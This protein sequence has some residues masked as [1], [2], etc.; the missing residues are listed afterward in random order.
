LSTKVITSSGEE[1][2]FDRKDVESSLKAAGL[3]VRVA[4]EVAERVEDRV[5]DR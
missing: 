4:E 1:I 5:Q 3:H 2:S